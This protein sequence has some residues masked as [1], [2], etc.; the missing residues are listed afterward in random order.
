MFDVVLRL[1]NLYFKQV[2]R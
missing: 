2:H 1:S